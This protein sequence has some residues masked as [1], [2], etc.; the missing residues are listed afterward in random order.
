MTPSHFLDYTQCLGTKDKYSATFIVLTQ[1]LGK[2]SHKQIEI[3]T[4]VLQTHDKWWLIVPGL[5][6]LGYSIANSGSTYCKSSFG[7]NTHKFIFEACCAC[8]I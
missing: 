1:L 5:Y 6:L 2:C 8:S 4:V 3:N 7:V